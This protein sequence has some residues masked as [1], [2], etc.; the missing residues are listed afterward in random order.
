M[1]PT[2]ILRLDSKTENA[3]VPNV[4]GAA[5]MADMSERPSATI[6]PFKQG[7]RDDGSL[8]NGQAILIMIAIASL[9]VRL[10]R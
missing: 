2:D 9:V 6:L 5:E 3:V 4:A 8:S 1:G 7:N 10:V